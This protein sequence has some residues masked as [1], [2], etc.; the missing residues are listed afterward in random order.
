MK[1]E[2][3]VIVVGAGPAGSMVAYELAKRGVEVAILEKQ[4]LPSL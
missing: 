2:Y 1:R 4:R 3:Q